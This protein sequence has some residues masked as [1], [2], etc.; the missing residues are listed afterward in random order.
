MLLIIFFGSIKKLNS[1]WQVEKIE[2]SFDI[3]NSKPKPLAAYIFTNNE[4]LKQDYVLNVPSGG[5]LINDTV[6]HVSYS[7]C[8]IF[9]I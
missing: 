9:T 2:D 8:L 3:I 5:M 6:L 4:Q 1:Y 7:P